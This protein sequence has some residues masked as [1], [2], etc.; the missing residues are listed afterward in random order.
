M[1]VVVPSG[2]GQ[3]EGH[4][5]VPFWPFP[6]MLYLSGVQQP[7]PPSKRLYLT[8]PITETF[9]SEKLGGIIQNVI[10]DFVYDDLFLK[11]LSAFLE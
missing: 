3:W 1:Q 8:L 5:G 6:L 9:T 11:Y 7:L 4:P 10:L 2:W